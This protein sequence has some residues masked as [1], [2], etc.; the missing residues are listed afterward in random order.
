ML[1]RRTGLSKTQIANWIVNARRRG[2]LQPKRSLCTQS[3]QTA[4]TGPIDI[5]RRPDTPAVKGS[6]SSQDPLQRWVD[7]PPEDEPA[8]VVAIARA[9]HSKRWDAPSAPFASNYSPTTQEGIFSND[10][11]AS[12]AGTSSAGSFT[13]SHSS[14][15]SFQVSTFN[16]LNQING[17]RRRRKRVLPSRSNQRTSLIVPLK[18]YQCTF[19]PETFKTKH[20]WQRHEKSFHLS[21][22]MWIC[23]PDE[24][25]VINPKT[26]Q[27]CCVFCGLPD[28]DDAHLEKHHHGNVCKMRK[29]EERTFYRKD[30]LN[31]HLKLVHNAMFLNWSMA[32]W[33]IVKSEIRS[34]CGFCG[35]IMNDWTDRTDHLAEHFKSGK[36]MAD[37]HGDWGFDPSVLEMLTNSIPPYLIENEQQSPFPFLASVAPTESPRNA[38][39]L[40]TLELAYFM[41]NHEEKSNTFPKDRDIQVEACRII[42]A[43][44]VL[45][46]QRDIAAESSWL[47][48]LVMS[49][50]EIA[51]SAR[52]AP[53][54]RRAE[55][56]SAV[57]KINGKDNL[58]E[59]CPLEVQLNDFVHVK[60]FRNMAVSNEMLQEE[61]CHIIR[62]MEK[63]SILPC[64]YPADWLMRL[65]K[66]STG[67]LSNFRQR[68]H[69]PPYVDAD[70][71]VDLIQV[72][73]GNIDI[74]TG[75]ERYLG[76]YIDSRRAIGIEPSSEELE[77][78]AHS[79]IY[80]DGLHNDK[81]DNSE[82]AANFKRRHDQI[83]HGTTAVGTLSPGLSL[84][85]VV[86]PNEP[87]PN[88]EMQP[89]DGSGSPVL[90]EDL[91]T[92]TFFLNDTDCYRRLAQELTRFVTSTMSPNN[93]NQH[94]P[95][96]AEIQ[97]QARWIMFD[98]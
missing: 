2:K 50:D 38:Y 24:P 26:Q 68:A 71:P 47:R 37:W 88:L 40:I 91:M 9:M 64:R 28:P 80:Q 42:Y 77:R 51:S 70:V 95:T 10:S 45:S 25:R 92:N 18:P 21:L 29:L 48:D 22:E 33:K 31:Q 13:Y 41:A 32:N 62:R 83:R 75:L 69:L 89:N 43:S 98:R 19:C 14:G 17:R 44:E 54:R 86:P 76:D 12:S 56:K 79:F 6:S 3:P 15:G 63:A 1:Q 46:T 67:W 74:Y 58:F 53:L 11:S 84:H 52:F 94:V 57:L 66:S 81:V 23:T 49:S 30:H 5:P 8:S 96:D 61:A 55:N 78:K 82:W 7:S 90:F 27:L 20:D 59:Q 39:E 16:S 97:Y 87:Q 93:P 36:T 85:E 34:R 73:A 72:T 60:V 4:S 65:V 35:I